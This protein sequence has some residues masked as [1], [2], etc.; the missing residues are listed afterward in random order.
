MPVMWKSGFQQCKST[1]FISNPSD[2]HLI[3]TSSGEAETHAA[4]DA[5]KSALNIKH[6]CQ[7]IDISVPEKVIIG[8]DAGAALGFINNT[9]TIGRMKH[10]DLRKEWVRTLRDRSEIDF[11]KVDGED[12]PADFFTKILTGP[13]FKQSQDRMMKELSE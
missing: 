10:I 5:A 9:A 13:K 3:S 8:I 2:E 6:V 4:A 12:N 7:E 11:I 1:G